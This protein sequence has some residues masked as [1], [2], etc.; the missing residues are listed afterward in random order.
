MAG[1][2]NA[3][4]FRQKPARCPGTVTEPCTSASERVSGG[5]A[6]FGSERRFIGV[7]AK[8]KSVFQLCSLRYI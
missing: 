6:R 4:H 8:S 1:P 5:G 2:E 7:G 3:I